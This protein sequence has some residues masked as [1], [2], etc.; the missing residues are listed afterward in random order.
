MTTYVSPFTGDVV[1]QTDVTYYAL[2]FSTNQTLHWPATV[3]PPEVPAARIIDCTPSTAGL[4]IALP[5][6]GQGSN[7]TDILFRN[8]GAVAFTVTNSAGG[9]SVS[10]GAGVSKYFYLS[11]NSTPAGVWQNVTFGTGTSSADAA[12]LQGAGLTTLAGKLAVTQDPSTISSTPTITNASRAQTFVWTG[13]NGTFTLPAVAGLSAGWWIGFRNNGTGAINMLGVG[14]SQVNNQ[15]NITIN[16][17]D[18]GILMYQSSTG[19][20]FTVGLATPSN[21]TFTSATYDVDAVVGPTFSLVS[22]APIIQTYVALSGSRTTSLNVLLPATTQLYI[23]VNDTGAAP[24][25]ITFQ[26]SGSA[27]PPIILGPG[28]VATVLS[29]GNFLYVLSQNTTSF[30][31]AADG[32]AAVPSYSFISDTNTGIYL[33]G[34]NILGLTANGV[35]MMLI[36]N[37]APLTPQISTPAEFTAL[38]GIKGGTF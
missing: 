22:Y 24:Y 15:P 5:P 11:D 37:S 28:T 31:F 29:D 14:A 33:A 1:Q 3:N 9:A 4:S 36:N 25:N 2:A 38:N 6:G 34:A 30:Y 27:Q 23:L 32:S 35:S 20:F 21:V 7:G 12:S 26:I 13:G 17:G 19:N 18:S 8:F 10:I 16:P